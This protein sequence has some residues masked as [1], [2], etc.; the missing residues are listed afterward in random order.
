MAATDLVRYGVE[1]GVAGI[2][3][4]R[5]HVQNAWSEE[6]AHAYFGVLDEAAAD[7]EV[8]VIV[9][10]GAGNSFCAGEDVSTMQGRLLG[11][12]S[13]RGGRSAVHPLTIPKPIIPAVNGVCAGPG[14]T[15]AALCDLRF[16]SE[17]ATFSAITTRRGRVAEDGSSWLLPRIIGTAAALDLLLSGRVVTADEACVLGLVTE[18]V[19]ASELTKRVLEYAGDLVANC[20]PAAMA[21]VKA[22]VWRHL[23]VDL[24]RAVDESDALA[25][26]VVRR[27]DANDALAAE[28]EQRPPRFAPYSPG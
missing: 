15:Q 23:D 1:A 11:A 12:A 16:A 13:A 19:P 8:R 22:Q 2:L 9:V 7:P 26:S 21:A 28:L 3:L 5:P 17:N 4:N 14:L 10:T 18:V 6:M 24:A 20:S 25:A 27:P